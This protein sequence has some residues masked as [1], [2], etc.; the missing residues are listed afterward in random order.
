MTYSFKAVCVFLLVVVSMLVAPVVMAAEEDDVL[1]VVQRWID[2]EGDL[3]EQAKLHRDDRTWVNFM[4]RQ[5]D[6]ALNLRMQKEA[7]AAFLKQA[8][9]NTLLNY[10]MAPVVKVY[11]NAAVVSFINVRRNVPADAMPGPA[12]RTF[13]SLV[14]IKEG[15]AW[16]I[17]HYHRSGSAN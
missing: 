16:K 17:G 13:V 4:V 7:R 9:G 2:L 6:E 12:N 3:D 14:L 8:P 15:S 11:G 1:N 5:T 10:M